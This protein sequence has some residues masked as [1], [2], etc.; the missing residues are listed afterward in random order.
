MRSRLL[1]ALLVLVSPAAAAGEDVANGIITVNVHVAPRTSL[2][3]SSRVLQFDVTQPGGT[4]AAAI[5]FTA[6][7]RLA[8]ESDVVLTDEPLHGMAGP[9]GASDVETDLTFVGEG[10]GMLTGAVAMARST[11]VGRWLGSGRR[12]G[13][14]V[15][16]LRA[17]AAGAYTLPV[18]FVLSTP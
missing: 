8:S 14:V 18:R 10:D 12:E 17:N 4:A 13:R 16:T 11:T 1:L 2:T 6:G 5:D 9:G 7:A 15:F 3:V